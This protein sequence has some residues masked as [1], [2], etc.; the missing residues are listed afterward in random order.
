MDDRYQVGQLMEE[1]AYGNYYEAEDTLIQRK[2]Q[3]LRYETPTGN[4]AEWQEAFNAASAE[5][6]TASH[7]GLPITYTH[8]IDDDGPYI[9]RQLLESTVLNTRLVE[10][11]PLSEYEGWELAH[12]MLEIQDAAK[13]SGNFHGAL[14]ANHIGLIARPSGKKLYSI[15]DYGLAE[16]SRR[17]HDS[18]EFLGAPYLISP[19]QARGEE[20]SELSQIY[21]IG[22]LVFHGLSG[23]HPWIETTLDEI[24]ELQKQEPRLITEYNAG[25]PDAM[26]QW[27][28]KMRAY[29][30]K[31]RFQSFEEATQHLPEPIQ[32]APVPVQAT[33]AVYNVPATHTTTTQTVAAQTTGQVSA[34]DAFAAQ[35]ATAD[36]QKK[37]EMAAK[38]QTFKNPFVL[39]G[40]GAV[41]LLIIIIVAMSGGEEETENGYTDGSEKA[42]AELSSLPREGLIAYLDFNEEKLSAANAPNIKLEPL[43]AAPIFSRNGRSGKGLILDKTRYYRL[44]LTGTPMGRSDK[45]FTISFWV[46]PRKNEDQDLVAVSKQP[47]QE[48]ETEAFEGDSA[49][50]VWKPEDAVIAGSTWN[51]VTMVCARS[52]EALTIYIDGEKVE[53]SGNAEINELKKNP[54][55][56]IGCDS[57]ENFHHKSPVTIDNMAIWDRK[58]SDFEIRGLFEQ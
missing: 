10:S 24:I 4:K 47:W 30:P 3:I 16:I 31:D 13:P 22:Q 43:N 38:M 27:I 44:P 40:I 18:K 49:N 57:N 29:D 9:I 12:Q 35:K 48:G 53:S 19:E 28:N 15:T 23:G 36:A 34:A 52:D 8:G 32:S 6:A 1:L 17:I 20:A 50:H 5:L 14:D 51:M 56:Y 58:L 21:A 39:G 25:I 45:D 37:A 55:I 42:Q 7:P 54:F 46:K 41:V 2:V 26:A 11:G 33:S